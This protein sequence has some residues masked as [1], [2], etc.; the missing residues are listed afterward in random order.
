MY[1]P[2]LD[3]RKL[4]RTAA[5]I[6]RMKSSSFAL[7]SVTDGADKATV[8]DNADEDYYISLE[9]HNSKLH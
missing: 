7:N 1:Y 5:E 2:V 9:Q 4:E 3:K 8:S 6:I